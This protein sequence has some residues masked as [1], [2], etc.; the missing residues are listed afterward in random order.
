LKRK[1]DNL[2]IL[3]F[4]ADVSSFVIICNLTFT[5]PVPFLKVFVA[6]IGMAPDS[7]YQWIIQDVAGHPAVAVTSDFG[8][9]M[10]TGKFLLFR[11]PY[12]IVANRTLP[13]SWH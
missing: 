11:V 1:Y 12:G 13:A 9:Q 4:L 8:H 6:G 3:C 2:A 7:C 10:D 5:V